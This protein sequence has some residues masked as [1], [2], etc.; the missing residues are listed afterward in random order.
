[1]KLVTRRGP[2]PVF[3]DLVIERTLLLHDFFDAQKKRLIGLRRG[4]GAAEG[5]G[6]IARHDAA[7]FLCSG[8]SAPGSLFA[9]PTDAYSGAARSTSARTKADLGV[10][11]F[12]SG[13]S[14]PP[15]R[16]RI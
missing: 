6:L 9:A 2:G 10:G 12:G 14:S 15:R 16:A 3:A 4:S 7:D 8:A 5:R 13:G 11:F 1:M